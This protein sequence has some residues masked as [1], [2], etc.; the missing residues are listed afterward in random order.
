MRIGMTARYL[1]TLAAALTVLGF[2]AESLRAEE[3]RTRIG[4][5][6]V[7]KY[8]ALLPDSVYVRVRAGEYVLTVVP[9]DPERFRANYTE[10]FWAASASN[11]G[12]FGLDPETGGLTDS[13]TGKIPERFFGLPFPDVPASDPQAGAKIVHNY[14]A[15]RMQ[16]DGDLHTFDLSDVTLTGEVLRTVKVLLSQRYY[17]GTTVQPPARLPDDTE[18]RQL[19]AALAP[20]DLEGVGI[21]TWRTNDWTTWDQVWAYLP[22][23]RRVRRV[24]SSTRGDLVPGFEVQGDDADCYDNK[25]TYFT[26]KLVGQ[27]EVIGP[28]GTANPYTL[29]LKDESST[30]RVME[31]PY[32]KAVFEVPG[33]TGAGWFTLDNVFVKRP[34]WLVEGIPKDP[35]YEAG[36]IL[37]YID[38]D[39]YHG[40]YKL[41]FS[42]A[43]QLYRTNFCGQ[44]WGR[45]TDGSFAAPSA[46]L[47]LGVNERENRGTPAGRFTRETFDRGFPDSWFTTAHLAELSN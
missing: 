9:V 25:T 14:R 1:A 47:M 10:R 13:A 3:Q 31:V 7:E 33:A 27:G 41:T 17:I 46:V 4:K 11:Q 35:Y 23:I 8:K 38:R 15:R 22:T 18:S 2:G 45:A 36:K 6:N 26:W 24:R 42:K 40:Y 21:L 32:N 5:D 29:S 16:M 19:A 43:G 34:V 44:A 37:L 39:L 28:I 20:K 30:Q 12:K